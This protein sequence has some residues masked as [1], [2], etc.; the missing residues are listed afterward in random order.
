LSQGPISLFP[1]SFKTEICIY[2]KTHIYSL[3]E[4]QLIAVNSHPNSENHTPVVAAVFVSFVVPVFG[5][6][7]S[8]FLLLFS[9][10]L[11]PSVS[12][13]PDEQVLHSLVFA[14]KNIIILLKVSSV[15]QALK[16]FKHLNL[17]HFD[18]TM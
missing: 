5:K 7:L 6:L 17:L 10:S 4:I 3:C 11:H 12:L 9:F 2:A 16:Y 15:G 1:S 14:T 13:L 18:G 8:L